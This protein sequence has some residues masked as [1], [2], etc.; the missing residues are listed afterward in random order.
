MKKQVTLL[1][2]TFLFTL[3]SAGRK[4]GRS[5][6]DCVQNLGVNLDP[7]MGETPYVS[8]DRRPQMR[9]TILPIP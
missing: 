4:S 2:L 6:L 9:K 5:R 3:P 8:T 7:Y 1:L